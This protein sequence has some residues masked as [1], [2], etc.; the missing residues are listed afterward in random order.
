M[1][2]LPP[3][4]ESEAAHRSFFGA[5]ARDYPAPFTWAPYRHYETAIVLTEYF[6]SIPR[7]A[8]GLTEFGVFPLK[9]CD[10]NLFGAL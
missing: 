1:D 7:A 6:G 4:G 10:L 8:S 2:L 5:C 3:T 9:L